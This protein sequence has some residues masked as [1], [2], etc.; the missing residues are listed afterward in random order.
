VFMQMRFGHSGVPRILVADD[1]EIIVESTVAI[2]AIRG[3]DVRGALSGEEA[4]AEAASFEPDLLISDISMR[5]MNGIEAAT[6]ITAMFPECRVLFQSGLSTLAEIAPS[7]P[8][9]L[10]FSF[11][12]KP[13]PIQNLLDCVATLLSAVE[14]LEPRFRSSNDV[15]ASLPALNDWRWAFNRF[16]RASVPGSAPSTASMPDA[17]FVQLN[18]SSARDPRFTIQ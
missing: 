5:G 10:V 16:S 6:R 15:E 11:V 13:M 8:E 2:L 4:V 12:R 1:E 17:R 18:P 3:Y 9:G 7:L 14:T